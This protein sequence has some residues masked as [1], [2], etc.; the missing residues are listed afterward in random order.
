MSFV[1]IQDDFAILPT[2][3]SLCYA[4]VPLLFDR[5]YR[6]Q[7]DCCSCFLKRNFYPDRACYLA[8][9]LPVESGT[10][11]LRPLDDFEM[12]ANVVNSLWSSY[13]FMLNAVKCD[14]IHHTRRER[15]R[16]KDII[17]VTSAFHQNNFGIVTRP[18]PLVAVW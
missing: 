13:C 7:G 1:A 16:G 6:L 8:T 15:R 17:L 10:S 12:S 18:F 5:L 3:K 2:G 9:G 11:F 4:L 14:G